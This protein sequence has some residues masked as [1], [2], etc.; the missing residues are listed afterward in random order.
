MKM[1]KGIVG[2][3][4]SGT[5]I[6]KRGFVNRINHLHFIAGRVGAHFVD[7]H[8]GQDI[9][10]WVYPWPSF[11]DDQVRMEWP[12]GEALDLDRYI[13]RDLRIDDG[14]DL[15][16]M[17]AAITAHDINGF[18]V[19]IGCLGSVH[20]NR[21][22]RRFLSD[23]VDAYIS[24]GTIRGRGV[25]AE[26]S[27]H[28]IRIVTKGTL[29]DS[30]EMIDCD[31]PVQVQLFSQGECVFD[32]G[33]S[34]LRN[35][36]S[37]GPLIM[38][39]QPVPEGSR[40]RGLGFRKRR[41]RT[42]RINVIPTPKVVF[43]HPISGTHTIYEVLDLT[44][45]GF[46]VQENSRDA[47]LVP[48]L[49][50]NDLTILFAGEVRIKCKAKVLYSR[51]VKKGQ[52][53]VGI[54]IV[55]MTILDCSRL[56][57]ILANSYDPH[58]NMGKVVDMDAL[59]DFF[60]SSGFIYPQKYEHIF[61]SREAFKE[62]YE[63]VYH[64][65]QEI[66]FNSTCQKNGRVYG[67]FSMMRAYPGV[68]LIHHLA[69]LHDMDGRKRIGLDLLNQAY[70]YLD[71]FVRFES[72]GMDYIL[73][74]FRPTSKFNLYFQV[75]FLRY[76]DNPKVCSMDL[77]A[78]STFV[79]DPDHG[80][81]A[82]G[83]SLDA[84]S[85]KDADVLY[86]FYESISGGL[87]LDMLGFK[88]GS[89]GRDELEALYQRSGFIRRSKIYS[90]KKGNDLM[91]VM[92]VDE[93]DPLVNLS[94]LVNC[95]KVFVLDRDNLPVEVMQ[96]ALA[97]LGNVYDTQEIQVMFYP[98]EYPSEKGLDISR[99]YYMW[100]VDAGHA[101]TYVQYMK[102]RINIGPIHMAMRIIQAMY[103]KL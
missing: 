98:H 82:P 47:R 80:P 81:L 3:F 73:L 93:S 26:F 71:G 30:I 8:S 53:R 29:K 32:G 56:F 46:S 91:A 57:D 62:L 55:D 58:A 17:S 74:A 6:D 92:V 68:M 76:V 100:V 18:T 65:G 5:D 54:G 51:K 19:D 20:T 36:F 101:D 59:W 86:A 7:K 95:I 75:G 102:K 84:Y 28:G 41:I 79:M 44:H 87:L 10:K 11:T 45:A 63:R 38:V 22:D 88:K 66:F 31:K 39:L 27:L 97:S 89:H 77:F 23:G 52:L 16:V 78:Y 12:K 4:M 37:T 21:R 50:I 48:G 9:V 42:P 72:S 24:Q 2:M 35:D 15:A 83:W 33:F 70:S 69:A 61:R 90:L 25:V 49:I 43:D 103:K 64:S 85:S 96:S 60:F 99:E 13:L 67:Q 40:F 94:D 34:H 14:R 1:P